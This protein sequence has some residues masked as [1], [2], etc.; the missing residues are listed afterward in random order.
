MFWRRFL[1]WTLS[2]PLA[3][4]LSFLIGSMRAPDA[5]VWLYV[6]IGFVLWPML[7]YV[8]DRIAVFQAES[9]GAVLRGDH[10]EA[11]RILERRGKQSLFGRL[12]PFGKAALHALLGETTAARY[13]LANEKAPFGPA[14][15]IKLV[16][17]CH[18][19]LVDGGGPVAAAVL[20]RLLEIGKLR[21]AAQEE[22]RLYVMTMAALAV[23]GSWGPGDAALSGVN[24]AEQLL[25]TKRLPEARLFSLWLR[26]Q[27]EHDPGPDEQ[28]DQI[29][30]AAAL[31]R[32]HALLPLGGRLDTRAT[33]VERAIQIKDP[34]RR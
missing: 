9:F 23:L 18:A 27:R 33:T 26:A 31:A 11:R 21:F 5:P 13:A 29:R 1:A 12:D 2:L 15:S 10:Q 4:L 30:Q 17:L 25:A 6:I 16:V 24:Q 3:Q 22:Y 19:D 20:F 7:G 32:A 34:Y 28:P 14:R 8:F